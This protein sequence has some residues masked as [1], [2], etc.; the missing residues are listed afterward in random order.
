MVVIVD[1]AGRV[2][3]RGGAE[4]GQEVF[5][6]PDSVGTE[7][8]H[9]LRGGQA[10]ALLGKELFEPQQI[11]QMRARTPPAGTAG[12]PTASPGTRC[13]AARVDC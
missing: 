5:V 8:M 13:P 3:D 7:C 4:P 10:S 6:E 11:R 12:T 9:E 1:P 2:V